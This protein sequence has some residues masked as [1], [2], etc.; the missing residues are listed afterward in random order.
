MSSD[1]TCDID[2]AAPPPERGWES[3]PDGNRCLA[4]QNPL[5]STKRVNSSLRSEQG[6]TPLQK[7]KPSLLMRMTEHHGKCILGILVIEAAVFPDLPSFQ[8]WNTPAPPS[9][10]LCR[11]YPVDVARRQSFY[12]IEMDE[13]KGPPFFFT[14]VVIRRDAQSEDARSRKPSLQE[15]RRDKISFDPWRAQDQALSPGY[16]G[17]GLGNR[18]KPRTSA[19]QP[20]R[21]RSSGCARMVGNDDHVQEG[22][23]SWAAE[24]GRWPAAA[25]HLCRDG[26]IR[27]VGLASV[28]GVTHSITAQSSTAT[29]ASRR[30]AAPAPCAAVI[31]WRVSHAWR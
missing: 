10:A 31:L 23:A 25:Q 26:P 17:A 19:K 24:A 16:T 9:L 5:S 1:L 3:F 28:F 14:G 29:S 7:R 4:R 18:W 30:R 8:L 2:L 15:L 13:I 11:A 20:S 21:V 6:L 12:A 27:S 22:L